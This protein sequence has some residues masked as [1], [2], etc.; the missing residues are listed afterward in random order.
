MLLSSNNTQQLQYQIATALTEL[1]Q[2]LSVSDL[3]YK[4]AQLSIGAADRAQL[5]NSSCH[6]TAPAADS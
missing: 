5:H 2:P 4:H 1:L 6:H 3:H